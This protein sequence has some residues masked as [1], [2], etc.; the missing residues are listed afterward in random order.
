MVG[1]DFFGKEFRGKSVGDTVSFGSYKQEEIKWI[2]LEKQDL[3]FLLISKDVLDREPYNTSY[4]DVTWESCT[5]RTWLNGPFLD[6]AFSSVK[7]SLIQT[8]N[9]SA[10]KNSNYNTNPGKETIDK[11]FLL[12]LIEAEKYF[13]SDKEKFVKYKDH[14]NWWWLRTPGNS[15]NHA[16]GALYVDSGADVS[17]IFG[18]IRPTLWISF[19]NLNNEEKAQ[20]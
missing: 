18:G 11:V 10:D 5:L 2:I 3:K 12:S 1:Y 9:V 19:K 4:K 13:P 8:T 6:T 7:K 20:G 16:A 17:L 15:Q 14:Y